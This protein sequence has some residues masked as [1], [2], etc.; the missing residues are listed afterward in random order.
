MTN[1]LSSDTTGD[2]RIDVLIVENEKLRCEKGEL[3]KQIARY[4]THRSHFVAQSSLSLTNE[5]PSVAKI[6][7]LYD[8]IT[9]ELTE[10]CIDVINQLRWLSFVWR[11]SHD[12]W[13][14]T[15][16]RLS[17]TPT[18]SMQR[19]LV[20]GV[21]VMAALVHTCSTIINGAYRDVQTVFRN[22]LNSTAFFSS[23]TVLLDA[24]MVAPLDKLYEQWI[25]Y[26]RTGYTEK[27]ERILQSFAVTAE[28][29]WRNLVLEPSTHPPPTAIETYIHRLLGLLHVMHQSRPVCELQW[30]EVR[31]NNQA[32]KWAYRVEDDVEEEKRQRRATIVFPPLYV[33]TSDDPTMPKQVTVP[34]SVIVRPAVHASM[35]IEAVG[36]SPPDACH[37]TASPKRFYPGVSSIICGDKIMQAPASEL[38]N[39]NWGCL[40]NGN[41]EVIFC[42]AELNLAEQRWNTQV[43]HYPAGGKQLPKKHAP[44]PILCTIRLGPGGRRTAHLYES[45]YQTSSPLIGVV[46][47]SNSAL[48]FECTLPD[49]KVPFHGRHAVPAA[50]PK[51]LKW[52]SNVKVMLSL[53][54]LKI[55]GG[56]AGH[57]VMGEVIDL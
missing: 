35:D 51:N 10:P 9:N 47:G 36:I 6:T 19:W 44:A 23:S 39:I 30:M 26:L 52:G 22:T 28:Q 20:D 50:R 33:L 12:S 53:W 40:S 38:L 5:F 37:V 4:K 32:Y 31:S 43:A 54:S 3:E 41:K 1:Q 15:D 2:T 25:E 18:D 49:N 11:L 7:R 13:T 24:A 55:S 34:G 8:D 42:Y 21:D 16:V 46:R 56:Y 57:F 14:S 17:N 45:K 29:V 48:W 27:P